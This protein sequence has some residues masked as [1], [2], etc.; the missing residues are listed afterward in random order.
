MFESWLQIILAVGI[1][2]LL[3]LWWLGVFR[4]MHISENVFPGGTMVYIDWKGPI[5]E[6]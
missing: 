5:K 2:L 1:L 6:I 4:T 3:F